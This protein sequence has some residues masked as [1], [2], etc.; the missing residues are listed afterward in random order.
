MKDEN[1]GLIVIVLLWI[2]LISTMF[3]IFG[4]YP[5]VEE[6]KLEA[7]KKVSEGYR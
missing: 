7:I 5:E 4:T 2:V 3:L 6:E 1:E